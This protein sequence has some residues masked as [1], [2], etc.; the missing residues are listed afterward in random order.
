MNSSPQHSHAFVEEWTGPLAEGFDRETD[1]ATLQVYLQK[2]SDD[3]LMEV[4]LPRLTDEEISGFFRTL[5]LTLRRH[6]SDQEYHALFLK[7][8]PAQSRE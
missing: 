3:G 6:L 4:L 1:L 7:N 2:F 5:A 8:S